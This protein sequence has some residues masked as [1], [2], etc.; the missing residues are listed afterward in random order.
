MRSQLDLQAQKQGSPNQITRY[1]HVTRERGPFATTEYVHRNRLKFPGKNSKTCIM[2]QTENNQLANTFQEHFHRHLLFPANKIDDQGHL[3][4]FFKYIQFYFS[5][6]QLATFDLKAIQRH[7]PTL[8]CSSSSSFPKVSAKDNTIF[9][10]KNFMKE[11]KAKVSN[12]KYNSLTQNSIAGVILVYNYCIYNL[13]EWT[14]AQKY[15]AFVNTGTLRT[16]GQFTRWSL[17]PLARISIELVG[18]F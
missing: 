9:R 8:S 3:S 13:S 17:T 18:N 12:R 14:R 10:E 16:E 15:Q 2:I 4:Y 7:F 5:K 11:C 6:L 1:V